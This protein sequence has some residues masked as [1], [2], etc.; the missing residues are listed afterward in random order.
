MLAQ[1]FKKTA[2]SESLT[3]HD[4]SMAWDGNKDYIRDF[5]TLF[6]RQCTQNGD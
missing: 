4:I 2:E 6:R 5:R 1:M 3:G